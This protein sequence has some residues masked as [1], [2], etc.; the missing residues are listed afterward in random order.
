MKKNV[1]LPSLHRS[2]IALFTQEVKRGIFCGVLS[3]EAHP[4]IC[5]TEAGRSTMEDYLIRKPK[6]EAK[7]EITDFHQL[8]P[9][10]K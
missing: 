1:S 10:E 2:R 5:P 4:K 6:Q 3:S 7:C 8:I 9:P